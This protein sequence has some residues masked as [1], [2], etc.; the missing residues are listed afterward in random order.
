MRAQFFLPLLALVAC[1]A[2]ADVHF[3]NPPAFVA[4]DDFSTNIVMVEGEY[5]DIQWADVTNP[6]NSRISVTM[7]QL[8]G[9]EFFGAPEYVIRNASSDALST[10]WIVNTQKNLTLSPMFY[11]N[12]FL[13]ASASQTSTPASSGL[14]AGAKAGIA[15][16]VAGAMFLGVLAG[17]LI[18]GRR[19]K[20]NNVQTSYY[21]PV[22]VD[23]Q[24]QEY[25]QEVNAEP[26]ARYELPPGERPQH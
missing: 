4:T 21:E 1:L 3:V 23:Y 12:L 24:L 18:L 10:P 25:P 2:V 14:S 17:W 6:N 13:E 15:I 11:L 16:G 19:A 9:T 26:V 20:M 7:W 5:E 8:N 22:K